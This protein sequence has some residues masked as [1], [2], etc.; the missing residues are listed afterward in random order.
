MNQPLDSK[1]QRTVRWLR[2]IWKRT[3]GRPR[4]VA[5]SAGKDSLVLAA[6]LYEAVEEES[7]PCLHVKHDFQLPTD[8]WYLDML[9]E[10]GFDIQVL[11][12]FLEYF[13]LIDRGIGFPTKTEPW[14]I[15]MLIGSAFLE[16]LRLRGAPGPRAGVMFRGVSGSE[17]SRKYHAPLEVYQRLDLPTVNPILLFE[18]DEIITVL[19]QRYGLPLNPLYD[20]V[21][22]TY[23]IC[24]Y[25]PDRQRQAYAEAQFPSVHSQFYGHIEQC[26]FGSD[27]IEPSRVPKRYRTRQE[28][29][30]EHGFMHW[31]RSPRQDAVG[32]VKRRLRGD[33]LSYTVREPRWIDAKHFRPV[34]G[35]WARVGND[36]RFWDTPERQADAIMKR[37]LNCLDCGFCMVQCF[38]CRQFDRDAGELRIEGCLQCGK[39]LN[40]RYCMGWKHRFW[41]RVIVEAN[42]VR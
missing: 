37:M 27:L 33:A 15:P 6:M 14:C 25:A 24:C 26:L 40:L 9:R 30:G 3:E 7:P 39:C 19:R 18:T 21:S 22:R 10:R 12:P 13:E 11:H 16:W 36:I 41:R 8:S 29:L 42:D 31:R 17:W 2:N 28:Q 5:F 32:A 20:K 35:R 34:A 1:V 23:C 4:F 38:S